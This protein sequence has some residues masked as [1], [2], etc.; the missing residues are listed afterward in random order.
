MLQH[1]GFFHQIGTTKEFLKT[2]CLFQGTTER[3]KGCYHVKT[4]RFFHQIST[5][6]EFLK[7]CFKEQLKGR[8]HAKTPRTKLG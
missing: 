8:F 2:C 3:L 5:A 1:L 4:P 7:T 6:T